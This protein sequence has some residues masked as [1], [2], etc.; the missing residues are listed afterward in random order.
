M[1]FWRLLWALK[2]TFMSNG[3]RFQQ[4]KMIGFCLFKPI[5]CGFDPM[6]FITME[7][8]PFGEY[9]S[10]FPST[11]KQAN[12]GEQWS[13]PGLVVL[14]WGWHPTQLY[15]DCKKPW[16]K[17]RLIK[18]PGFHGSCHVRVLLPVHNGGLSDFFFCC[19][20]HSH[21]DCKRTPS[22]G[23]SI[24]WDASFYIRHWGIV[25]SGQSVV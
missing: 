3:L 19:C 13:K 12:L 15:G 5:F 18:Q 8:P 14:Y 9:F 21:T 20:C 6:G 10:F 22:Y 4:E 1:G 23:I 7:T 25:L 2:R 24:L 11:T 17:D 16:N